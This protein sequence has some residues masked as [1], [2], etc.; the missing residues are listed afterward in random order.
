LNIND[1]WEKEVAIMLKKMFFCNIIMRMSYLLILSF[2]LCSCADLIVKNINY[3]PTDPK[4]E[5]KATVENKGNKLAGASKTKGERRYSW[6]DPYMAMAIV[7]TPALDGGESTHLTLGSFDLPEPG[8]CMHV[9][10]C[11]DSDDEVDE[12]YESNNCFKGSIMGAKYCYPCRHYCCN[13]TLPSTF[14]WRNVNGI[15]WV[16]GVRNQANCGS[17]WAFAAVAA[18]EAKYNVE[19]LGSQQSPINLSEQQLLSCP[20]GGGGCLGGSITVALNYV[21]TNGISVE[22]ALP[23]TSTNCKTSSNNC[24]TSCTSATLPGCAKPLLT[25]TQCSM[26]NWQSPFYN[27]Q[28]FQISSLHQVNGNNVDDIKRALVCHG[29]LAVCSSNWWHCI[30]LV[31]W[32]DDYREQLP[33]LARIIWESNNWSSG[34]WIIK[35]SWGA[36]WGNNGYGII[37]FSGHPHSDIANSVWYAQDVKRIN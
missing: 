22:G 31:G 11:A 27:W 9:R 17:C 4:F 13:Q 33:G 14:D 37:P 6:S 28:A 16:T 24:K 30:L 34:A 3:H 15:S 29:P 10:V 12:Q 7:P 23:Y 32:D 20:G 35:N 25:N 36:G 18:V 1:L 19:R 8:N 26:Q 2:L 21:K 5:M